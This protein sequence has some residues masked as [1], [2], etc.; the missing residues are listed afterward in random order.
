MKVTVEDVSSVKKIMHIEIPEKRVTKEIDKAYKDLKKNVKIK[1]FR[2]GKVPRGVLEK[3]FAKDVLAD[4]RGALLQESFVDAISETELNIVGSPTIDPPE[5]ETGSGYQYDATVEIP[6][7]IDDIEFKGLQVK[8]TKY[9][10]SDGEIEAQL[11]MLQRRLASRE[12]IAEDRELQDG[13]F[14]Q[15]DYEGFKNGK[16]FEPLNKTENFII[17]VGKGEMSEDFDK[18]I[19]GMKKGEEKKFS[20]TFPDDFKTDTLKGQAVEFEVKLTDIREEVLPE[21]N[22]DMAKRLGATF[23]TLD[24]LK[25]E[26]TKNLVEGYDK[27]AEQEINEQIFES[28]IGKTEFE[29]PDTMV[30]GELEAIV[31]EAEQSFTYHNMKMEDMGITRDSLKVKYLETAEKQVRRHLILGKIVKQEEMEL[32]EE[33]LEAGFQSMADAY[34]QPVDGIKGYYTS[35]PDKL[36]IFKHTLLEK[37]AIQ[38]IIDNSQIEEVE[39]EDTESTEKNEDSEASEG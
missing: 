1:G 13:D 3:R 24:D 36:E 22:D 5:L 15:I 37:K 33:E 2:Q 23:E 26:I 32:A 35:N 30:Q 25:A 39:P 20:L 31:N 19:T 18:E 6:P 14:A 27:R 9:A 38:L 21:I 7:V 17:E 10:V 34:Q 28:L 29:V 8:K 4:V 16:P 11:A 12:P